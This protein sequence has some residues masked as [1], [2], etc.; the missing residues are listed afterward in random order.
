MQESESAWAGMAQPPFCGS[1]TLRPFR[2]GIRYGAFWV[3]LAGW[4]NEQ[5]RDVI[6]YLQEENRV[7]PE[8]LGPRRLRFTDTQRIRLAKGS[9]RRRSSGDVGALRLHVAYLPRFSMSYRPDSREQK[10]PIARREPTWPSK[11]LK[12]KDQWFRRGW[13]SNPARPF[14]ICKLQILQCRHC[15]RCRRCRGTLHAVARTAELRCSV[16]REPSLQFQA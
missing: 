13:D 10:R 14:R 3:A 7:L 16:T 1:D 2:S 5:Q 15:H 6:D 8:Q 9:R 4:I 11:W 12:T